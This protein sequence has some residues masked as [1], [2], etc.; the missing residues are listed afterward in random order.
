MI[1]IL[2]CLFSLFVLFLFQYTY[3]DLSNSLLRS[4]DNFWLPFAV[5]MTKGICECVYF[6]V[7]TIFLELA[8]SSLSALAAPSTD[9]S[10]CFA[11]VNFNS[12]LQLI[13]GILSDFQKLFR[14]FNGTAIFDLF[15]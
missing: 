9:K 11:H 3:T 5:E 12:T 1:S 2:I 14:Y 8:P 13:N 4:F 15:I 6:T 10:Q 7:K